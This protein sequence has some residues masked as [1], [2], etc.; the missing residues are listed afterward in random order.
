MQK[1]PKQNQT[2]PKLI[3]KKFYNCTAV[4]T[5]GFS[6]SDRHITD[7]KAPSLTCLDRFSL[8]ESR[9]YLQGEIRTFIT[10]YVYSEY[11]TLSAISALFLFLNTAK[12]EE[13]TQHSLGFEHFYYT[14]SLDHI[15]LLPAIY[16]RSPLSS[17]LSWCCL[18]VRTQRQDRTWYF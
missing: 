2:W 1:I 13:S 6:Q 17:A 11:N 9:S 8:L 3:K 16:I 18:S 15:Q 4:K 10:D 12:K 5:N 14:L 7:Y